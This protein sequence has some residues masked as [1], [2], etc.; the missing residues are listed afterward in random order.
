MEHIHTKLRLTYSRFKDI[1][2]GIKM[3]EKQS[4]CGPEKKSGCKKINVTL[5]ENQRKVLLKGPKGSFDL[6]KASQPR[7]IV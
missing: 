5:G 3:P 6:R 2:P 7:I 1:I 4:R